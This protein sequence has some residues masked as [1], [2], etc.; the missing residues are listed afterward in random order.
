MHA[1]LPANPNSA[2]CSAALIALLEKNENDGSNETLQKL[3]KECAAHGSADD[4]LKAAKLLTQDKTLIDKIVLQQY[5]LSSEL[6]KQQ[7]E[8]QQSWFW[9]YVCK[10]VLAFIALL[11]IVGAVD[12]GMSDYEYAQE[13]ALRKREAA[14]QEEEEK[15][16]KK[17]VRV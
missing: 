6:Q 14:R 12:K 11:G 16:K 9:E 15:A 8:G 3:F 4:Q 2:Q 17:A 5:K 13:Q 10:P 1:S 7:A